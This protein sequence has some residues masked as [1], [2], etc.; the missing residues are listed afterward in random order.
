MHKRSKRLYFGLSTLFLLV[1]CLAAIFGA[2][3]FGYDRGYAAGQAQRER[4]VIFTRLYDVNDLLVGPG[5]RV[6]LIEF[7]RTSVDPSSWEDSGGSA[8]ISWLEGPPLELV[9][10]QTDDAHKE[11]RAYLQ[12]L[13]NHTARNQ[14]VGP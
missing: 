2:A 5:D 3:R 9:I 7:L 10:S 13:R 4:A 1:T 12:Q 8:G 14:S 6:A 11:V